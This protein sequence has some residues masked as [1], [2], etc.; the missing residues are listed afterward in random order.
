MCADQFTSHRKIATVATTYRETPNGVSYQPLFSPTSRNQPSRNGTETAAGTR[1]RATVPAAPGSTS[2][3]GIPLER[4]ANT[5]P[6]P[7]TKRQPAVETA[8]PEYS[9]TEYRPLTPNA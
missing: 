3:L 8:I 6:I 1:R 9:P 5:T 7:R 4:R 2:N